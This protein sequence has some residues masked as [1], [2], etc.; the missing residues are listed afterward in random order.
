VSGELGKEFRESARELELLLWA[1]WNPIGFNVPLD[2]YRR[3]VP[4]I[5]KLLAEHAD[6]AVVADELE[7]IEREWMDI[8]N[9]GDPRRAAVGDVR[10]VAERLSDWWLWRFDN[11]EELAK[12]TT[13]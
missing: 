5:W 11:P 13:G 12:E 9:F 7:R 4:Q 6:A 10:D 8:H 1:L 3:Y 2:E